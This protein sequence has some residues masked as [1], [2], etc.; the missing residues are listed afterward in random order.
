MS[1]SFFPGVAATPT[2]N[3]TTSTL[4]SLMSALNGQ[5]TDFV[6][7]SQIRT[8]AESVGAVTEI[9]G[10][11]GEA[12]AFQ[13]LVLGAMSLFGVQPAAAISAT[14]LVTF[15]TSLPVSAAPLVPQAVVIP[16]GTIVQ[17]AG[18]IQFQTLANAVLASGTASISAGVA[19]TVAGAA[20]NVSAGS[21]TGTPLTSIG[22]PLYVTNTLATAG[23]SD[24]GSQS[25]ALGVF[26]ARVNSLGL[27]SPVA[28]ANS[29][30]GLVSSGTGEVVQYASVYEPW[31]AAGSGAGSGVSS[32][33]LYVDNGTGGA[34]P[35]LLA[36][37][38]DWL[39]GSVTAG[40][41]GYRPVGV[42]FTVSAVTPVYASAT[43]SGVVFP[44][45]LLASAVSQA[46]AS[47]VTAYF[48]GLG[49][50][51]A[52]A[53]QS[54]IAGAAADAGMSAFQSLTVNLYYSGSG[55]PTPVV[56]GGVGTR[57]ILANL[58]VNIGTGT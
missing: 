16:S 38:I 48:N 8:L 3:Q 40:Q 51:P 28:V 9:Q 53:Y 25:S 27:A 5:A 50:A 2:T 26:N 10:V 1:G 37:V 13:S 22:Y 54:Q 17:S 55:T 52:A 56:S 24:A 21:I 20:G 35:S 6:I 44:G 57:V 18:G 15:A 58:T 31:L 49:I 46:V 14:G 12:L 39:N 23:G 4:L 33:T 36:T 41:S 42:P 19:A 45:F 7:G 29:A 34:S 47:G 11:A 32:F 43:V 30:I